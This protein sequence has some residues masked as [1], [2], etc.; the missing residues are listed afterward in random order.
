MQF[1]VNES[2]PRHLIRLCCW[3]VVEVQVTPLPSPRSS[4]VP[5]RHSSPVPSRHSSPVMNQKAEDAEN[6]RSEAEIDQIESMEF[7]TSEEESLKEKPQSEE[8]G[9]AG[10]VRKESTNDT[11]AAPALDTINSKKTQ[12]GFLAHTQP[13]NITKGSKEETFEMKKASA[14]RVSR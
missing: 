3:Q 14:K 2:S 13:K 1:L 10:S 6:L 11:N 5:S 7:S 4:P 12:N 8:T 9:S